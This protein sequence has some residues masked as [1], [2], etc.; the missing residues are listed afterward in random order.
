MFLH[1]V[2]FS[3]KKNCSV[4]KCKNEFYLKIELKMFK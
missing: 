2:Q 3:F 4:K 1:V